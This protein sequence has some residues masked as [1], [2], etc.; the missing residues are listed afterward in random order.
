MG[1]KDK[2]KGR[3]SK[4]PIRRSFKNQKR[5]TV[6]VF[7]NV[8]RVVTFKV[9]P[10][11]LLFAALFFVFYIIATIFIINEYFDIYRIKKMHTGK[12]ANLNMEIKI[13]NKD[14]ER[15]KE[16]IAF[17]NEYIEEQKNQSSEPVPEPV[18]EVEPN[19]PSV[20]ASRLVAADDLK[21]KRDKS[22]I[23][24]RF[25]LVNTQSDGQP[26]GGYIFVIVSLTESGK[27][28]RWVYPSSPLKDG[29]PENYR[30]GRRFFIHRFTTIDGKYKIGKTTDKPLTLKILVYNRDGDI[31][32]TKI[33][34]L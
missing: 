15:F 34:E 14:I 19:E 8:G 28:E 4:K 3:D 5:L 33:S 24:V 13:A 29:V 11:I 2:I 21:V 25:K 32:L 18:S 27:T 9:S 1:D 12:I 10:G 22:T 31:I 23:N 30:K 26:I 17:L 16:D 20:A 6:M 7:K